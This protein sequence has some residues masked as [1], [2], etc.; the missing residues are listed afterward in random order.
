[1]RTQAHLSADSGA[2]SYNVTQAQV[3]KMWTL[4]HFYLWTQAQIFLQT[5]VQLFLNVLMR[6]KHMYKPFCFHIIFEIFLQMFC[7]MYL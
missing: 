2:D 5:L 4:A 1:M 3:C 6:H 7:D